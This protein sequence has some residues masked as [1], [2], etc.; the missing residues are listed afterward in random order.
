MDTK[1]L[2]LAVIE[3]IRKLYNAEYNGKIRVK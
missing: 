3:M 1:D 2:E